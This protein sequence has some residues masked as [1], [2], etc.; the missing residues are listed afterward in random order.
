MIRRE[1]AN[2]KR[3]RPTARHVHFQRN[4]ATFTTKE[5]WT[6]SEDGEVLNLQR[7]VQTPLGADTI[8]LTSTRENGHGPEENDQ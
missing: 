4:S 3:H 8:K 6:L 1:N 2:R 5:T 7:A